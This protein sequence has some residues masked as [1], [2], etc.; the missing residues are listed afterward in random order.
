MDSEKVAKHFT[1][2]TP[3]LPQLGE[4]DREGASL[5]FKISKICALWIYK[6]AT[7]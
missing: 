1:A 5:K 6:S 7:G 2:P 4:G 3:S